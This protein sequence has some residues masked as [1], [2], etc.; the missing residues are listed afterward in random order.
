MKSLRHPNIVKLVGVCWEDSLFACCLEFVENESL[1]DWLRRTAGG[2]PYD[3]SNQKKEKTQKKK[4]VLQTRCKRIFDGFDHT[5]EYDSSLLTDVDELEIR[6]AIATMDRIRASCSDWTPLLADDVTPFPH[7]IEGWC[8]FNQETKWGESL[9]ILPQVNAPPSQVFA[10]YTEKEDATR[11]TDETSRIEVIYE[12]FTTRL[13]FVPVPMPSPLHDREMLYRGVYKKLADGGFIHISYDVD[14]ERRPLSSGSRRMGISFAE[15]VRPLEGSDG[16]ASEVY[17]CIRVQPNFGS[18]VGSMLNSMVTKKSAVNTA[19]PLVQL[20][21]ETE[22]LLGEYEPQLG[23][24]ANG[25]QSL[26]WRGQL[27]NIATQCALGVQYLH[28]EQYWAD[29]EKN[30]DGQI[31]PAGFRQCIIHR[32]LKPDNMLLTKDWQLKL[33]DFGEARAVNCGA[34]TP[35]TRAPRMK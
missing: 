31:I 3:P 11:D 13:E 32:D 15:W 24:D 4:D 17:R 6:N 10:K 14:D 5:S 21:E 19:G 9:A 29:E 16:K 35:Q 20:K 25:V 2:T 8:R 33:T 30:E 7:S 22:R 23:E 12:D 34:P 28:Q 26:T 27:L 18:I 1:E